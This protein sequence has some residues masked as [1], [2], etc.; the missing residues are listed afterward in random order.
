MSCLFTSAR[1]SKGVGAQGADKT[2]LV[3]VVYLVKGSEKP[4]RPFT[5]LDAHTGEIIDRWGR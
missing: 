1:R 5:M 2:R 3:A 4:S